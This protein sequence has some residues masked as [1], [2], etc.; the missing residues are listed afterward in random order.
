[1][2][3]THTR[4]QVAVEKEAIELVEQVEEVG[5][6]VRYHAERLAQFAQTHGISR[7]RRSRDCGCR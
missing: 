1:M 3:D 4:E 5:W 7:W 6:D 2:A